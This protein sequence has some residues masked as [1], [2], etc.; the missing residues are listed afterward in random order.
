LVKLNPEG[1]TPMG[2]RGLLIRFGAEPSSELTEF[3]AG[4][5]EAAGSLPGVL[6]ASPGHR[7]VLVETDGSDP[8]SLAAKLPSLVQSVRPYQPALH[9]VKLQYGGEDFDWACLHLQL[10]PGA[11]IGLHSAPLYDVR[12]LGSPGFI[13]LSAVP[14][15]ISLPRLA[16]PRQAVPAGSV[17]IGGRQTGIYGRPRP[18]G[19]RI[20][21]RAPEVPM[22]RP[23]DTI[24]FVPA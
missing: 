18:G 9:E 20:L 10:E 24:R 5:A 23:G 15:E 1:I 16:E 6:D 19:W 7:T 14:E 3:L 4:L 21:A 2:N 17:G 8:E 11:L 22:V 12:L 13:Y